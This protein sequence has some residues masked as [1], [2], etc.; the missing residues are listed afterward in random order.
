V[1]YTF[2]TDCKKIGTT[3]SIII[4]FTVSFVKTG[5]GNANFSY[6]CTWHYMYVCTDILQNITPSSTLLN[7]IP[8]LAEAWHQ[9]IMTIT[10]LLVVWKGY[11]YF[12]VQKHHATFVILLFS[13]TTFLGKLWVSTKNFKP[14]IWYYETLRNYT[15]IKFDII[16]ICSFSGPEKQNDKCMKIMHTEMMDKGITV[17]PDPLISETQGL[18]WFKKINLI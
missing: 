17:T 10:L 12:T 13:E 1:F 15:S 6:W 14:L 4:W 11:H 8:D 7:I 18:Q 16:C 3:V 5:A 9:F 2:C